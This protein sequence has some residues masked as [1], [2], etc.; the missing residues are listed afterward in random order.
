MTYRGGACRSAS[1]GW[2]YLATVIDLFSG[3]VIAGRGRTHAPQP[4]AHRR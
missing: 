3:I 4:A 2:F 1:E